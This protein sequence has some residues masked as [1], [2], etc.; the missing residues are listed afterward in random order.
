MREQK[1]EFQQ[2]SDIYGFSKPEPRPIPGVDYKAYCKSIGRQVQNYYI[3]MCV[4]GVVYYI[5]A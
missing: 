1:E 3:M 5:S 2:Y 4:M